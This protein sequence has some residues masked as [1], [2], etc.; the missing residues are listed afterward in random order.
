MKESENLARLKLIVVTRFGARVFSRQEL[1]DAWREEYPA[2]P[3]SSILPADYCVNRKTG[4]DTPKGRSSKQHAFLFA[5]E[6]GKYRIYDPSRDGKW[7]V[8]GEGVRQVF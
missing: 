5:V 1:L 2:K 8:D 3:T 4:R 7:E 6:D